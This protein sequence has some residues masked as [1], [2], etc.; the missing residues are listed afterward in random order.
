MAEAILFVTP[1]Y[2][3]SI[4]GSLKNAIDWASRPEAIPLRANYPPGSGPRQAR[5]Y[6]GGA[7]RSPQCPQ[8]LRFPQMNT[9]EAYIQ[10][11]LGLIN[12]DGEVTQG[13]DCKVSTRL[14]G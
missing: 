5:S 13:I 10:F 9:L 1:E 3:R 7:A 11:T 6:G 14:Y 4:P 12:V 8:L 2:N